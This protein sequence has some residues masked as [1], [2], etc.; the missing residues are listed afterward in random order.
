MPSED[1]ARLSPRTV[2]YTA[3]VA[4]IV[5]LVYL[6]EHAGTPLFAFPVLDE[7]YYETV[8]RLLHT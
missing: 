8:A 7:L 4:L 5:R 2:L 6:T 1:I 3:V